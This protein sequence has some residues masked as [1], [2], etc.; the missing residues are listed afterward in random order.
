MEERLREERRRELEAIALARRQGDRGRTNEPAA[1]PSAAVAAAAVRD[2]RARELREMTQAMRSDVGRGRQEEEGKRLKVEEARGAKER[3][4]A[5]VAKARAATSWDEELAAAVAE[6]ELSAAEKR[7]AAGPSMDGGQLAAGDEW[8]EIDAFMQRSQEA[9]MASVGGSSRRPLPHPQSPPPP[10]P[11][12][13]RES[14]RG[15]MRELSAPTA[16]PSRRTT[17]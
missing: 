14:S 9:I 15:L 3:E 17:S 5:E 7:D 13:P 10:P 8:D 2:D 6:E 4:L 1:V 11:A 12:P 16:Q